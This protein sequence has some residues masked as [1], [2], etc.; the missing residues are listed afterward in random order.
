MV[1]LPVRF[2][3]QGQ[4]LTRP[5]GYKAKTMTKKQIVEALAPYPDNMSVFMA[6]RKT[7]FAYGLVNSVRVQEIAFMEEPGG[8]PISH[9]NVIVFDEE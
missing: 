2:P 4:R 8:E 1:M 7:E 9:D 6:E 3:Q 5:S